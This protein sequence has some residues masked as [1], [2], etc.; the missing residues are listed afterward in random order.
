MSAAE[1][2]LRP[3]TARGLDGS[4][5]TLHLHESATVQ[6]VRERL[7]DIVT[8][9]NMRV[10]TACGHV[11]DDAT[12]LEQVK[13]DIT[14]VSQQV[15]AYTSLVAFTRALD[16]QRLRGADLEAKDAITSL[17]FDRT[18]ILDNVD[19]PKN[20]LSLT[21]GHEFNQS[22]VNVKFPSCLQ[23]LTFG[24]SFNKSLVNV[25]LPSSLECL[26]FGELFNQ[27]L[28]HVILPAGLKCLTLGDG[29]NQMFANVTLPASLQSLKFGAAFDYQLGSLPDSLES[30]TL[31]LSFNQSL[32]NMRWPISLKS[33]SI[34]SHC[35]SSPLDY[36]TLPSTLQCLTVHATPPR[37]PSLENV[38]LP[39]HLIELGYN[40]VH[41]VVGQNRHRLWHRFERIV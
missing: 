16:G 25:E 1:E 27:S 12:P 7:A 24:R 18:P 32:Q 35:F 37:P 19:L 36:E 39:S 28:E 22:L 8:A 34:P 6:D 13:G 26:T 11:L 29:F 20:L 30:L 4:E 33:L 5:Q 10:L 31:G 17:T 9:G 2:V 41:A 38:R 23:F 21:F 14:Y 15:D 3:V 40:N